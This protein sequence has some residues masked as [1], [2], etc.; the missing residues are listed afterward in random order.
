MTSTI[1][2]R[3]AAPASRRCRPGVPAVAAAL[4]LSLSALHAL[5]GAAEQNKDYGAETVSTRADR[6]SGGNVLVRIA[7]KHANRNHPLQITLNGRDVSGAFRPG[8][9]DGTLMG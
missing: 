5:D 8:D 1:A 3:A 7:Y 2:L 9:D 6:V 4:V